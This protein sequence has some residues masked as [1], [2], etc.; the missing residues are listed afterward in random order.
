MSKFY[1]ATL[2]GITL[3]VVA[4]VS[5]LH[6]QEPLGEVFKNHPYAFILAAILMLLSMAFFAVTARY[7]KYKAQVEKLEYE[8]NLQALRKQ[9]EIVLRGI[10]GG[11]AVISNDEQKT[12]KYVN[13]SLAALFGYDV[14]GFLAKCNAPH[15]IIF[16]KD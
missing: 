12:F 2:C 16:K 9:I 10:S 5:L 3:A 15:S 1:I 4:V 11:F 7:I 13:A 14:D 8:K 6:G